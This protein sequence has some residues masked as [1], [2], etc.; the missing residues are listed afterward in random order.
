MQCMQFY[1]D[2]WLEAMESFSETVPDPE[3]GGQ[4]GG[5]AGQGSRSLSAASSQS[6]Q[7]AGP[8]SQGSDGGLKLAAQRGK[9]PLGRVDAN[10]R[11][12]R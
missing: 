12:M 8:G 2:H 11:Q 3:A 4:Q 6:S 7:E 10:V 9:R 5:E 1:N